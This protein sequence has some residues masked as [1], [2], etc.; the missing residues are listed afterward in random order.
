MSLLSKAANNGHKDVVEF[1]A[2]NGADINHEDNLY[3][4]AFMLGI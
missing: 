3:W 1:L 4:N 2:N